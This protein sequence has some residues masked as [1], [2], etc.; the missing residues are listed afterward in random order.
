MEIPEGW[1]YCIESV[2][3]KVCARWS[4][5]WYWVNGHWQ[6]SAKTELE[7]MN[8]SA[9]P[10]P[11]QTGGKANPDAVFLKDV[12]FDAIL[13]SSPLSKEAIVIRTGIKTS[14]VSHALKYLSGCGDIV[15][16]KAADN[17]SLPV[18]YQASLFHGLTL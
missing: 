11:V 4:Y 14:S 9:K 10:E 1:Q 15:Y 6:R 3:Y 12:V 17:Y 18:I 7:L 5:T 2:Y 8:A 13:E 16:N